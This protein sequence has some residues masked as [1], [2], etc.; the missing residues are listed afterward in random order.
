MNIAQLAY[1][2]LIGGDCTCSLSY[3]GRFKGYNANVKMRGKRIDFCASKLWRKVSPEIQKGLFQE[4]LT[5][6]LKVKKH[7]LHID[8]YN[9]FMR[10]VPKVAPVTKADIT[11][12]LSFNRV[13]DRMFDGMM[14]L[15]NLQ[16]GKGINQLG[17]YEYGT[18]TIT[19]STILLE[20]TK[21]LDYV[22]YH[23]MLHKKHQFKKSKTGSR[24]MH[25][26]KAFRDDEAKFPEAKLLDKEL[27]RL[28]RKHKGWSRVW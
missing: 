2:E 4:L 10:E 26:S 5:R 19:I 22:M 12:E 16:W 25:H 17:S 23:E 20:N 1:D 15:P 8:L 27:E 7:T 3:S 18:N 9:N 6:L 14:E 21:L 13:N 28:V 24:V 11:L